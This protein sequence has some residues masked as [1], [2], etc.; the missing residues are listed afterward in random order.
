[1]L[2]PLHCACQRGNKETVEVMIKNGAYINAQ[3]HQNNKILFLDSY[4]SDLLG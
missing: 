3:V 4:L 1:M 2:T